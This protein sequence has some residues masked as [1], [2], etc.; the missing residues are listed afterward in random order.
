MCTCALHACL[1]LTVV[2]RGQH[3]PWNGVNAVVSPPVNPDF[4]NLQ[5]GVGGTCASTYVVEAYFL[6]LVST[7]PQIE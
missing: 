5:I 6:W 2:R 3:I 7:L 1:V 4:K